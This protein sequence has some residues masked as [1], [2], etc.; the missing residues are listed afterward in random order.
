MGFIIGHFLLVWCVVGFLMPKWLDVFIIEERRDDWK[1][2]VA[3]CVLRD[4]TEGEIA[5]SLEAGSSP[6]PM[7]EN[8]QIVQDKDLTEGTLQR[9]SSSSVTID[10]QSDNNN[11]KTI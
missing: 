9:D 3:P 1:Q 5:D 6:D 7:Q 4:T 11:G 10:P 8:K 2:P